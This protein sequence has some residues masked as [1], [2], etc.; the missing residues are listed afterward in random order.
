VSQEKEDD[1]VRALAA[2]LNPGL[3]S[4]AVGIGIGL[5]APN[6]A[7]TLYLI[8]ALFVLIPFRAIVGWVR[9]R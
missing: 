3:V 5:L 6:V 2:K 9:R 8:I 1:D 4:Y 7:V